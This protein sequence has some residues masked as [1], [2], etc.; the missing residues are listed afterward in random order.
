[1]AFYEEGGFSTVESALSG[2][3]TTFLGQS[4]ANVT[5]A[6][7]SVPIGFALTTMRLILELGWVAEL[8]DLYVQ[9]E[10]RGTGIGSA[11]ISDAA[12]WAR[13]K[14]ARV[15]EV[16]IAPNGRDVTRLNRYYESRSFVDEGRRIV[17]LDL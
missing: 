17:H 6:V 12:R 8:Q 7:A 1:M 4:G 13:A 15:L 10:H 11:L 3:F 5:V 2:R 14:S 16:V 9:L